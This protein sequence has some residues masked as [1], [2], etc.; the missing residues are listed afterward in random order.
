MLGTFT[1]QGTFRPFL[2]RQNGISNIPKSVPHQSKSSEKQVQEAWKHCFENRENIPPVATNIVRYVDTPEKIAKKKSQELLHIVLDENTPPAASGLFTDDDNCKNLS[3]EDEESTSEITPIVIP[4]IVVIDMD[5]CEELYNRG[6]ELLRTYDEQSAYDLLLSAA[7]KNH[8]EAQFKVGC[9]LMGG[10]GTEQNQE[11]GISWF[12]KAMERG[13]KEA[14][15]HLGTVYMDEEN[16]TEAYNVFK[17]A[18]KQGCEE[19]QLQCGFFEVCGI[20]TSNTSI[21][22]AARLLKLAEK[23]NVEA[24]YF[25][26]LGYKLGIDGGVDLYTASYWLEQAAKQNHIEAIKE[27]PCVNDDISL[28]DAEGL[29]K[30]Y[31][32]K[33]WNRLGNDYLD[34]DNYKK[35]A[36]CYLKASKYEF[37]DAKEL[38]ELHDCCLRAIEDANPVLVTRSPLRSPLRSPFRI[39]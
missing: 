14:A 2:Q 26:G 17:I 11:E 29:A 33:E 24:Q 7:E 4:E 15:F 21:K 8:V 23:N 39:R 12:R 30:F 18:A 37:G 16:Y 32:G 36:K 25:L 20:G 3:K 35:A 34:I 9:L 1:P 10:I 22:G 13:H 31:L 28:Y 19:S 5:N 27:L 38:Q 6:Y